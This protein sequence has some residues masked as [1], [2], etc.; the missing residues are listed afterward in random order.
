MRDYFS[1]LDPIELTP[2]DRCGRPHGEPEAAWTPTATPADPTQLAPEAFAERAQA[3]ER[4]VG[5]VIVGQ[6]ELVRQT[7]TGLLANSHVLLEGVPGPG[8][9]DARAHD[10]RRHRLLVQPHPVHAGP[11]AGRHHRH[12]HPRRGGRPAGLPVPARPD[13][14]QPRPGRRDQP[15][16]AQDPVEPARGDAG[17]PGHGRPPAL[18][19]RSAVLRARDPEPARDGGHVSPARGPARPVLLQGHGP[20]PVRGG[21]RRDHGPHDRRRER[22]RVARCAPRPRSS[23]C[24]ASPAPCRS[25]RTSPPTP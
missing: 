11:D 17:A 12:E 18:P 15:G 22:D 1:S 6:R 7:L 16:D 5:K 3:I 2:A 20:V 8:Q 9:D 21:P 13:L 19:A 23:R 24:S 10:R 25:P 14:R 4:E